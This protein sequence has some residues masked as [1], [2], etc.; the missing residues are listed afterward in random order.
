[1]STLYYSLFHELAS[2]CADYI[3]GVRSG[4]HSKHA[5]K[6][7]YRAL[8]HNH[9]KEQCSKAGGK[10]FPKEIKDFANHYVAMQL[11]RHR[12]DYNPDFI[13]TPTE[14]KRA[15]STTKAAIIKLKSAAESDRRAFCAFVLLKSRKD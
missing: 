14:V 4:A 10:G 13:V 1:M 15:I 5:W 12:S 7:C 2:T 11:K 9:S 3:A 6:Q 8:E